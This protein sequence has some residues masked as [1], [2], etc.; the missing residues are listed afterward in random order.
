MVRQAARELKAAGVESI[1]VCF[2]FS[3]LDSRHEER[4]KAII[5]EEFPDCFVTTSASVSPQFREFERFTTTAMNAFIGPTGGNGQPS[6]QP[7]L[8]RGLNLGGSTNYDKVVQFFADT[9][10]TW[11]TMRLLAEGAGV[12]VGSMRDLVY[13]RNTDQFERRD[14]PGHGLIMQFRLKPAALPHKEAADEATK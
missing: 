14:L 10:N 8:L 3:Y 2:L 13:K 7:R 11:I 4:A 5:L 9:K 1:A 6:E 12:T